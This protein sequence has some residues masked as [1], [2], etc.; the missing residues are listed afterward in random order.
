MEVKPFRYSYRTYLDN[1]QHVKINQILQNLD[2]INYKSKNKFISDAIEYYIDHLTSEGVV[3]VIED[4][5]FVT[6]EEMLQ[7]KKEIQENT[8]SLVKDE[9]IKSLASIIT[10]VNTSQTNIAELESEIPVCK[11]NFR[12]S[13]SLA[14]LNSGKLKLLYFSGS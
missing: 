10:G 9:I 8:I 4:K 7:L 14:R 3:D 1:P 11:I 5:R 12:F 13:I 2:K 6:E